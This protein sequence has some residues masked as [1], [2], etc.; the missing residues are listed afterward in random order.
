MFDVIIV[1][2]GFS[3]A[4][5][6]ERCASVK[7]LKVLIIEQREHIAGNCFDYHDQHGVLIH[8]YGP[9]IFHT[10][11]QEVWDYLSQ[12]TNWREYQH[13]VLASIDNKLIPVPFNL[14]SLKLWYVEAE[15]DK[16]K[17]KLLSRYGYGHKIGI[18]AL[19]ETDDSE[20]KALAELI[21][22]KVFVNYTSKQWGVRPEDISP[23]VIARV[24]VYISTDNRYFQ[25]EYQAIPVDGYSHLFESMV[26]HPNI[27]LKLGQNAME[28]IRLNKETGGIMFK[29]EPFLGK[30]VFTGMIDELFDFEL[31]E[32]SYRSLQFQ[33]ENHHK[34]SFQTNATVNY[35]NEHLYTRITEFKKITGQVTNSTTIVK[36]FPQDYDRSDEHKNVPYY[37]MFNAKN[38]QLYSAYRALTEHY[39]SLI[40]FGRLGDFKYYNM[41][42]A[43]KRSLDVFDQAFMSA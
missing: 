35:P 31:G 18:Q 1:G 6:A 38:E 22:E 3:G 19:R 33:F 23:E 25:D 40:V 26:S 30:V 34:E 7:G 13:E 21:Y 12:F 10:A 5:F 16:L 11:K 24:P 2:A 39:D 37:P 43:V 27:E 36:E 29:G 8:K 41:D 17:E 42:D 14:N 20:L 9:H 4:V 15:A 28:M 32:L